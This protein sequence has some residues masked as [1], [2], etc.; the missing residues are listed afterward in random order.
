MPAPL[1]AFIRRI[2]VAALLLA[3]A[4]AH[5]A[6]SLRYAWA[7]ILAAEDTVPAVRRAA[8]ITPTN[9]AYYGRLATLD[10]DRAPHWLNTA[11][12]LQPNDSLLWIERA[13]AAELAGDPATAERSLLE[14]VHRDHQYVPQ[15]T[16]AAFYF[17]Q[18]D[19]PK[20]QASARQAL[21]MAWGDAAPL[22]QMAGQ[23]GISLEDVRR[24]MLPDR[25][26]VLHAFLTEC[27]RGGDVGQTFRTARRL[28]EIGT[29]D[30]RSA[31]LSAVDALFQ[32]GDAGRAVELWNQM[33]S[34]HWIAHPPITAS[35][36]VTNPEF[37]L[38]FLPG[39]FD[40]HPSTVDGIVFWRL[41]KGRGLQIEFSGRQPESCT[42][43]RLPLPLGAGTSYRLDVQASGLRPA[44]GLKWQ[45]G[46]QEWEAASDLSVE[47]NS[48]AAPLTLAYNRTLG[49]ARVEGTLTIC[50]VTVR[51]ALPM[52]SQ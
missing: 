45:L 15:W 31:A 23:L 52:R 47:L 38:E 22:F 14:A 51:Q 28:I 37:S 42:L 46:G 10:L 26:P 50:R 32:G 8:E 43:I 5:L 11:L 9:A 34:V 12:N 35:A 20:F 17:R 40:W 29:A 49:N 1:R 16:L 36:L 25:A 27:I 3:A 7:N 2:F 18:R 13:V 48:T 33:A 39:G 6:Y 44:T 41:G 4:A 30:N 24:T 19:I 21:E